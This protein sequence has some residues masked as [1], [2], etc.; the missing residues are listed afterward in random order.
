MVVFTVFAQALESDCMFC[1]GL[2]RMFFY[3]L[4]YFLEMQKTWKSDFLE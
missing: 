1:L 2:G 3:H 4:K